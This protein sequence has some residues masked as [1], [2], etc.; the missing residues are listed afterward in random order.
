M[1]MVMWSSRKLE[2]T[3]KVYSPLEGEGQKNILKT[4]SPPERRKELNKTWF[5]PS[6][7]IQTI[8]KR[9]YFA[10]FKELWPAIT[11]D[12]KR[13]SK[14]VLGARIGVHFMR[15]GLEL[16]WWLYE[17]KKTIFPLEI[18]LYVFT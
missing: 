8:S 9:E 13:H 6:F 4:F 18:N 10:K 3:E 1:K 15:Q 5:L 2:I 14:R 12:F 17:S 16:P 7:L 11:R